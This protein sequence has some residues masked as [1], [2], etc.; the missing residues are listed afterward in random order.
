MMMFWKKKEP[1]KKKA[2]PAPKAVKKAAPA[3]SAAPK[4]AKTTRKILTAE[5]WKRLMMKNAGKK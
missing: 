4:K 2:A 3:P 1:V 5:G